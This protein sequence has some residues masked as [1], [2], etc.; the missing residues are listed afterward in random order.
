M[1]T[2]R[3]IIGFKKEVDMTEMFKNKEFKEIL[4]SSN[5]KKCWSLCNCH[6]DFHFDICSDDNDSFLFDDE[7]KYVFEFFETVKKEELE[8]RFKAIQGTIDLI[9]DDMPVSFFPNS[10]ASLSDNKEVK[11]P[12]GVINYNSKSTK[13]NGEGVTVAIIDSGID[14]KHPHFSG[15]KSK[16][17]FGFNFSA[18]DYTQIFN[19]MDDN[20]HGTNVSGIIIANST[21]N[22]DPEG[23]AKMVNLLSFKVNTR[24]P[25]KRVYI[26]NVYNAIKMAYHL[27]ADVINNSWY[28]DDGKQ[29]GILN[30][31]FEELADSACILVFGAGNRGQDIN[32]T[33]PQNT[34]NT[35]VVGGLG[36][37]GKKIESSDFGEKVT[38]WAPAENISTTKKM[39][40]SR[41]PSIL[42]E[43]VTGTSIATPFVTATIALLKQKNKS[44][45]FEEV[46]KRLQR[47]NKVLLDKDTGHY[48]Y[49]LDIIKT[50]N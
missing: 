45:K 39:T 44:I 9:E 25:E 28:I 10:V 22:D 26:S 30:Q 38:V 4:K 32:R 27:G 12:F 49:I 43:K 37:D 24:T 7:N 11:T 15:N 18:R 50:I 21:K 35:I 5:C 40:G 1:G 19:F 14:Y 31:L 13:L 46:V 41:N 8:D 23:I 33:Y 48:G 47:G 42:T 2:S 36:F 3:F 6:N 20:G 29:S 16:M 34:G 17:K